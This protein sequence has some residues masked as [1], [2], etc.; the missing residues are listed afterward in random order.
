MRFVVLLLGAAALRTVDANYFQ[1]HQDTL[2]DHAS[3]ILLA[4]K[5]SPDENLSI[6]QQLDLSPEHV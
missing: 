5:P 2:S 4:P 6:F 1:A 3:Q